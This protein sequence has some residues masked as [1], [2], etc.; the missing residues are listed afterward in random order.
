MG[1]ISAGVLL[2]LLTPEEGESSPKSGKMNL[3]SKVI[4]LG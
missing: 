2:S 4:M 3:V 1:C